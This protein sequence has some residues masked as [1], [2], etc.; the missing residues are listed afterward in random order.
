M[1]RTGNAEDI[2]EEQYADLDTDI[3]PWNISEMQVVLKAHWDLPC[4][5]KVLAENFMESYHHAVA[6]VKTLQP[7]M[8]TRGTWTEGEKPN[9]VRCHLTYGDRA[10]QEITD[11]ESRGER[12]D[13][14]P[15]VE[16]LDDTGRHEW[17]LVMGYPF[18]TVVTA[19]DQVVWYR[20]DPVVRD[21][22]R[23]LTSILVPESTTRHPQFA[24]MLERGKK[25]ATE[26][27]LEDVEML[28][29]IQH[30]LYSEGY[31]RGRLSHL[32]MPMWQFQRYLAA[33]I[34]G[35]KPTLDREAAD[36]QH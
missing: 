9:Y 28:S 32:E 25:E 36:R 22:L 7:I 12:W 33:T 2:V 4:N 10:R 34:C 19:P 31:Q 26:F 27:N 15:T 18:L 20:I 23:L 1:V 21:Q 3:A 24:K 35:I 30:S 11:T 6:H 29:A 16:G 8:P 14:F 13:V 5:W 17:G